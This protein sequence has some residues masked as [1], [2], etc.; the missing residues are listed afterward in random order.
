MPAAKGAAQAVTTSSGPVSEAE[1]NEIWSL[2]DSGRLDE[3][4]IR[5]RRLIAKDPAAA[6]PQFALGVLHY[7]RYWRTESVKQWQLALARDRQIRNDPQFGAYLCFML[8]DAWQAAGVDGLLGRLGPEAVPLL[9]QCVASAKTPRLRAS[10]ARA[11]DRVR[12]SDGRSLKRT[13]NRRDRRQDVA[14]DDRR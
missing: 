2:L 7:R 3:G 6:W 9:D 11:L 4:A 14:A 5:I 13:E 10:A 1:R 12:H 8:D